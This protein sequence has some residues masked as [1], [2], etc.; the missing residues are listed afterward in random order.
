MAGPAGDLRAETEGRAL[1]FLILTKLER[2]QSFQG[3]VIKRRVAVPVEHI[4]YLEE[5]D[6]GTL[7]RLYTGDELIVEETLDM[8]L[9]NP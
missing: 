6:D 4:V 5:A 9:G 1:N 8:L 3:G 2:I 7:I